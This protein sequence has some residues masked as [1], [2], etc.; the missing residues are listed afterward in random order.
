MLQAVM[1]LPDLTVHRAAA[2]VGEHLV[3]R[4]RSRRSRRKRSLYF[5]HDPDPIG[6]M[7]R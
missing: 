2:L 4:T 5:C 6:T 1:R 7:S 3:N